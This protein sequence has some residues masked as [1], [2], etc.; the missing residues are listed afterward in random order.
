MRSNRPPSLTTNQD[1]MP[2]G[3]RQGPKVAEPAVQ[4]VRWVEKQTKKGTVGKHVFVKRTSMASGSSPRKRHRNTSAPAVEH[5]HEDPFEE[6]PRH[7]RRVIILRSTVRVYLNSLI[8]HRMTIY[9]N[10]FQG[11]RDTLKP[12]WILKHRPARGYAAAPELMGRGNALIALESQSFAS[13]AVGKPT[14]RS[15]SIVSSNGME[16]IL[17]Q[18]GSGR[19]V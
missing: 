5:S 16:H 12:C 9:E 14:W 19:L 4:M 7:S 11:G 13:A 10:G 2:A 6:I 17:L 3:P 18:P 8:R 1:I 15:P